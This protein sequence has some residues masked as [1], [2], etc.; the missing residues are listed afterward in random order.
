M[1][2]SNEIGVEYSDGVLGLLKELNQLQSVGNSVY[3]IGIF[4]SQRYHPFLPYEREDDNL[5][6]TAS[7]IR[8]LQGIELGFHTAEK[9]L[10]ENMRL[11]ALR[12]YPLFQNKDGLDTYNFWQTTPSRH[13]PNGLF[14]HRFEHFQIPDD[15]D[16]TAL[17]YL[18]EVADKERVGKLREK[19]KQHSNLSYKKASNPLPAYRDLKCYSTFF[20]KKMYIEFDVCV[21]CNLMSLILTHFNEDELNEYDLDTLKFIVSVIERDEFQTLPFYS[22]PNYPTTELILYHVVRLLPLLPDGFKSTVQKKVENGIRERQSS[23]SGMNQ[24]LMEN[25]AMKLGLSPISGEPDRKVLEDN[26]FYFF[27]AGMITAFEN[28]VAQFLAPNP[29]FHLRYKSK[30]LNRALLIEN[31]MLRR[32]VTS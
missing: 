13:F 27:H 24:I 14:M 6:F 31:L 29:L 30:A 3:P 12:A 18:T 16:D 28:R 8:M 20:G 15:V 21:L 32:S 9:E 17:V 22:A 10:F 11:K 5:F 19:L 7:I 25:A 4:P 26:D 23:S 2:S 1:A